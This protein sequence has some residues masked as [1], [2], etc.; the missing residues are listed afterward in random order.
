MCVSLSNSGNIDD[1]GVVGGGDDDDDDACGLKSN[2]DGEYNEVR[3]QTWI[4]LC[5][6]TTIVARY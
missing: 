5:I 3:L 6:Q 1:G 4:Y 2:F